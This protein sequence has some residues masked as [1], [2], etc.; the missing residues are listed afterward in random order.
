MSVSYTHLKAVIAA[1]K[2]DFASELVSGGDSEK[3]VDIFEK[4]Y[5]DLDKENKRVMYLSLIHIL[6]WIKLL[7]CYAETLTD[8]NI[9]AM[10]EEDKICKYIDIPRQ[11]G[12]DTVL[13]R[14][15]RRS[16]R[17]LITDKI[18]ALRKAMP[19]IC[20]RT[21]IITGFPGETEEEFEELADFV[22]E[23]RFDKLGVFTYSPEEGTPAAEM[24]DQ[25]VYKRQFYITI[26]GILCCI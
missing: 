26:Q 18:A 13:K 8:E 16:S 14:M 23:L 3:A 15:G 11:H 1:E 4:I 2:A 17:K 6:E 20:I 25:D 7:Y 19:D 10:A 21:T 24:K 9:Q 5:D 22:K 12:S